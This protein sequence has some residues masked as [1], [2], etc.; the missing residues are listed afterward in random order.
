M[1]GL[2]Q[3]GCAVVRGMLGLCVLL[4]RGGSCG[5]CLVF[6]RLHAV[7]HDRRLHERAYDCP[8]GWGLAG[9]AERIFSFGRW[10]QALLSGVAILGLLLQIGFVSLFVLLVHG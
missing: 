2:L 7:L 1:L 8:E 4:S 10:R 5:R 3:E 9:I 6:V